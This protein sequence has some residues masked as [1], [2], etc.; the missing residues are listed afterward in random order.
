MQNSSAPKILVLSRNYPNRVTPI[1]GLWV[2][3]LVS[4][5]SRLCEI[6]VIAPTPY[7]PPLPGLKGFTRFRS[8]ER[9]LDREGVEVFHPRFL[10]GPG[11]STYNIESSLYYWSIRHYIDRLREKFP[12]DLIHANFAYPDGVVAAKLAERYKVPFVI[13]EHASWTP[14]M[15]NYPKV[16]RQAIWAAERSA[17]HIAVSRFARETIAYYTGESKKL[18]IVPNGVDVDIFT[19]RT[20][21]ERMDPNQILYVGFM[22]HVKGIDVLLKAMQQLVKHNPNLKLVLVG[23][24]I[25][26]HSQAQELDLRQMAAELGIEKHVSFVGIK[27]R[28]DVAKYMRQSA[29]LV[30]PSRT[31]TFGAVLV[32]ALACGTPVVATSCGGTVDIVNRNVGRLVPKE[33]PGEL[34]KAIQE[35]I[36]ERK[37]FDPTELRDY[38][39]TNFSWEQIARRTVDL[40]SEA[41]GNGTH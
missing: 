35:V 33:N 4:H 32:E 11:Y 8:I 39:V 14:W 7:C 15:D 26:R 23:G 24:G 20:N 9:A 34:A 25:Y 17:F 41:L 31:E 38:A 22:R 16:H 10:T 29:V 2:E 19:P 36:S 30:L 21:G 13:T 37:K 27:S 12:F 18:R 3:S 40:Y 1:L 5:V 6:K 28:T